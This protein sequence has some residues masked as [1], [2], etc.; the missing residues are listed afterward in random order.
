MSQNPYTG[1][2]REKLISRQIFWRRGTVDGDH[3]VHRNFMTD[4]RSV[5]GRPIIH[6]TLD[7]V[8]TG[9]RLAKQEAKG[10]KFSMW[11][12]SMTTGQQTCKEVIYVDPKYSPGAAFKGTNWDKNLWS[13]LFHDLS[14][15]L[16]AS[17][18]TQKLLHVLIL[19]S[20][21]DKGHLVL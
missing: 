20:N 17:E 3:G 5:T 11:A 16:S 4:W 1:E 19:T 2:G 6:T 15:M 8:Q 21:R 12:D 7:W 13:S 14:T 9:H 18:I 10:Q